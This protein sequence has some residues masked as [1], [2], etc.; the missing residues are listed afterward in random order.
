MSMSK[1]IILLVVE[2]ITEDISLRG[3]L[4][5]L[6]ND[7]KIE[8]CLVR[9]DITTREDIR[10]NNIK[11][12]LGNIVKNFLGRTFRETDLQEVIH[13]V[14]TDGVYIPETNI[15]EDVTL[16]NFVYSIDRIKA[17]DINKVIER[18]ETKKANL[19]VLI[20][21][22][23]VLKKIPY[24]VYYLSQNLEH[25]FH[26]KLNCSREEKNK[27]AQ[28]LEDRYI[29]DL[30]SFLIFVRDSKLK[31][32]DDYSDSWDYIKKST[33]SLSRC[34]NIHIFLKDK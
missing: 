29:E 16:S 1:K 2:G 30:E 22:N 17:K 8:F 20:S 31:S 18:N 21:T 33:N 24:K 12:E 19:E 23:E 15:E 3:I 11:K 14:D 13:L 6:F 34:S 32:P 28:L 27:L 10:P 5:E 7:K 26:D 25:F 9:T 4:S